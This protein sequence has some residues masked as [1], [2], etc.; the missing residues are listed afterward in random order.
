MA[1]ERMAAD[2]NKGAVAEAGGGL[3]GFDLD[4]LGDIGE[5]MKDMDPNTLQEL[6]MEGL[7]DPQVQEMVSLSNICVKVTS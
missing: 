4:A 5:L 1:A 7:K 2:E 6:V 3:E